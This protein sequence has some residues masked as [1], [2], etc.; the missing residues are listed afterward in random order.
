MASITLRQ[1]KGAALTHTEVDNNFTSINTE[2]GTKVQ[3]VSGTAGRVSVSGTTAPAVDLVSGIATA[4]S[5]TLASI[6]VDTYGRVTAYSSGTAYTNADTRNA[7]SAGTGVS[8]NS[9]SGQISVD[10]TTI[11][12]RTYADTAA[13]TAVNNVIGAAP[14]ALNTLVE[15]ATALGNDASF[16]TTV[17]NSIA[18]K[19]AS[20]SGTSGRITIGGTATAPS[21]DLSSGVATAGSATY[22][23]IT[24]D[25]YGRITAYSSG[26]APVTSVAGTSGRITSSGGTTPAIDLASGIATAG[27]YTGRV[28]IDTYGRVTS[29]DNVLSNY[30]ELIHDLG[31]TSTPTINVANGNC[32]KITLNGNWT[33]SGFASPSA[34]H[35]VTL[36]ITQDA[37]GSRTITTSSIT[38]KWAGGAYADGKTL[39]TTANALDVLYIFFDGSQYLFTLVKGFQ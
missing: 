28:T 34:G 29:A 14:A 38:A 18:S 4:G 1:T 32:Q 26:T 33:F 5:A 30:R 27:T 8:Y 24:V 15:L 9:T 20:V 3:S 13:S 25:T 11:A 37:T 21:V 7:L 22:A 17:T 6:T 36:L 23:S 12:T 19:V 31:T 10:T 35:N 39:T 16:S 2:L